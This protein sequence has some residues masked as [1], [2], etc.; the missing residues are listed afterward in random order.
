MI[1]IPR[2]RTRRIAV[3]PRE[4]TIGEAIGLCKM[5]PERA[6]AAETQFLRCAFGSLEKPAEGYVD[7]PLRMTVEE[8]AYLTC[9]YLS[10]VGTEADFEVAPG[11]RLGDY[12]DF[13]DDIKD[14]R[15][16]LGEVAG[17]RWVMIPLLGI[18]AELLERLCTGS[19]E[20]MR[21][22]FAAQVYAADEVVPDFSDMPEADA[23]GL[24]KARMAHVLDMPESSAEG[25]FAAWM[26][27]REAMEH[28]FIMTVDA[29]G[30]CFAARKG[31]AV[32]TPARFR[33]D[34]CVGQLAI[35]LSR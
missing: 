35:G 14:V 6:H 15:H 23:L 33:V 13:S 11:A 19:G 12:I 9:R 1:N 3:Q 4:I 5:P 28:F 17:S 18:H 16:D 2:V 10:S 24:L 27:G 29:D 20:W 34:A 22:M 21:G 31:A 32:Q 8:R 7:D 26:A 25:L 30:P